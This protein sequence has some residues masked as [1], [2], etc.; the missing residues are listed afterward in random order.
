MAIFYGVRFPAK[1]RDFSILLSVHTA[2]GPHPVSYEMN[3]GVFFF[4]GKAAGA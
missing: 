2:S 1:A 3:N 4:G